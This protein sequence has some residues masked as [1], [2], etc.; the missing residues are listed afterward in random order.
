MTLALMWESTGYLPM[1]KVQC[2]WTVKERR[3]GLWVPVL[4][5]KNTMTNYGLAALASAIGGGYNAPLYLVIDTDYTYLYT[6]ASLGATS[7][8][9]HDRKDISGDTQLII[10]P[11]TVTQETVT[12]S[13]APTG[14]GPYTYTLTSGLLYNHNI[15]EVVLRAPRASDD[16]TTVILEA[17]Y[18]STNAP[19]QRMQAASGYS[20]GAGNWT[21][22]FYFTGSQAL[23]KFMTLGLS[24]TP[25]V[26]QGNLHNH[27]VLGYDHSGGG[28]DLE[29]DVSLTLTN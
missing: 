3:S 6:G 15:N 29:V 5:N 1:L 25:T 16:L 13:G 24:E 12:F 22:Q 19:N 14:S 26:G 17:Q 9:T 27:V 20:S 7:I 4:T 28:N 8:Q 21:S 18:D 23:V 2:V 11:G 10:A